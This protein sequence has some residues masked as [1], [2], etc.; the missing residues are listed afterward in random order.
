MS[1]NELQAMINLLDDSDQEIYALVSKSIFDKGVDVVP[2][3]EKAWEMSTNTVI[4]DKLEDIIHQIQL[5]FIQQSLL[6]W[7]RSGADDILEGAYIIARYQYP[8]LNLYEI[9]NEVKK[10]VG[11]AYA[12]INDNL[13]ATEKVNVINRIIY[14]TNKF[15]SNTSN[16]YSPQNSYINQVIYSK[17]GSP[18]S[19]GIIYIAVA[20]RLGVPVYGVNL[21]KNFILGYKDNF[22][23]ILNTD[24][25]QTNILFYINPFNRGAILGRREIDNFLK[26]QNIKMNEMFYD[27]CSNLEIIQRLILNLIYS[28][29]KLGY[30]SK[31]KDLQDLWRL[32][33]TSFDHSD[34]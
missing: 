17:K 8:E 11:H 13:T 34:I 32:S 25:N 7:I 21:P 20:Y 23:N 9:F 15:T 4:Q 16:Y 1:R 6:N 12:D 10:I 29:E 31:V 2:D 30:S 5:N 24:T 19:L 18:I 14:D 22:Y 27:T 3:L 33:K 26:Q 28:Y